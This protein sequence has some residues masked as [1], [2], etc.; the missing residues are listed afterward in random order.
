MTLAGRLISWVFLGCQLL[1]LSRSQRVLVDNCNQTE[2]ALI[3]AN[4]RGPYNVQIIHN[5]WMHIIRENSCG[6]GVDCLW[7]ADFDKKARIDLIVI[8]AH[9]HTKPERQFPEQVLAF[10]E[11][12][13]PIHGSFGADARHAKLKGFDWKITYERDSDL[14]MSYA[15]TRFNFDAYNH[16]ERRTE[17]LALLMVSNCKDGDRLQYV[18]ELMKHIPVLSLGKC[19]NNMPNG[20]TTASLFPRCA[21]VAAGNDWSENKLCIMS[22]FKYH[23]AF[24]NSRYDDYVTEKLFDSFN[25]PSLPIYRGSGTARELMPALHSAIMADD[26]ASPKALAEYIWQLENN[27]NLYNEYFAWKAQY[28]AGVPL[29]PAFLHLQAYN[30]DSFQ[31]NACRKLRTFLA[32]FDYSS[33]TAVARSADNATNTS[34][35]R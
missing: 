29:L 5:S 1:L 24:E 13:P 28:R 15:P 17:Y 7:Q 6:C 26:F 33:H 30:R 34:V 19:L 4:R 10:L 14:L 25:T 20:T 23:L 16:T 31:C 9:M 22:Y 11:L 12:E 3:P 21:G 18:A 32:H 27:T 2:T 35:H 8:M